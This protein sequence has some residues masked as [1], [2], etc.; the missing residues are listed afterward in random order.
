MYNG[1]TV[2]D[3]HS[4]LRATPPTAMYLLRLLAG[5]TAGPSPIRPGSSPPAGSFGDGMRDEDFFKAAD[6][7]AAYLDE[8][9]ID[10][11]ILGPHPVD[12][13]GW[14]A[15]HIFKSWTSYVNDMIFKV[16]QAKP[17]RWV[18]ACQ[19][20]QL[21][22]EPDTQH[23]LPEL[24]RCVSEY[25]FVA[26]YVSPDITGRRDTPG[27]HEP[28]WYPLYERCQELDIPIIVHGTDGQDPRFRVVPQN[29]QL[30]FLS[31]QYFASQF[32]R[33]S[34]VFD[35]FP[36]L[37]VLVC[38]CGGALDRFIKESPLVGRQGRDL[39]QNLYFDT[40]AYDL[41]YLATAIKQRG[42]SQ[43]CFGVEAPGSGGTIRPETGK[44]SDDLVPLIGGHPTLSFLSERE[45]LDIFHNN[46]AK[47]CPGLENPLETNARAKARAYSET[48][49]ATG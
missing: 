13:N 40:C 24:E 28:Y 41:D 15:P 25:G 14:M 47:F 37:K 5:N 30:A 9:N 43:M 21:A 44:T 6:R 8:R 35:K 39:S 42:I 11:Q 23:V 22:T 29:Y 48:A 49:G 45:K 4:H 20:P 31:E 26:T 32:L 19:L 1:T 2:L 3:V 17:D 38:H 34:D 33:H 27:M 7:H 12:A 36:R 10:V 18:G 46:P 16:V